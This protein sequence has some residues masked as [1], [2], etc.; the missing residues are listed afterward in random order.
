[1]SN[2]GRVEIGEILRHTPHRYPFILVDR[3]LDGIPSK[4]IRVVKNVTTNEH[5]F[6]GIPRDAQR[7]PRLLLVEAFAQCCGVLCHFSGLSKPHGE[8]LTF[9]AGIDNCR[10][11][12]EVVPGDQVVFDCVLKRASRGVVKFAGRG[13]VNDKVVVE[14]ETTAVLRDRE[15]N[16]N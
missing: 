5:F 8:T 15:E 1:M 12:G 3:A 13:V 10:F 7:M 14:L 16:A 9:F 2:I 4:S 6:D 11:Y